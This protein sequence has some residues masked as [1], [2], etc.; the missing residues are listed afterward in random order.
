MARFE[1]AIRIPLLEANHELPARD[2]VLDRFKDLF[3]ARMTAVA[4]P[5]APEEEPVAEAAPE[6]APP[7]RRALRPVPAPRPEP[8]ARVVPPVA[9]PVADEPVA[10]PEA[11]AP[12]LEEEPEAL[13]VATPQPVEA[14][15]VRVAPAPADDDDDDEAWLLGE[16]AAVLGDRPARA[17]VPNAPTP[18]PEWM[19]ERPLEP[20]TA[21]S[22]AEDDEAGTF[23]EDVEP[24]PIPVPS[25]SWEDDAAAGTFD[26]EPEAAAT[27]SWDEE[28]DEKTSA[29]AAFDAA[30]FDE[31]EPEPEPEPDAE[32]DGATAMMPAF[33]PAALDG[34][35]SASG[36]GETDGALESDEES[37]EDGE[38]GDKKSPDGAKRRG[39]R[40][41]G[42]KGRR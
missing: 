31:P 14:A 36:E 25:A 10:A 26:P 32:L 6:P 30:D 27:P 29:M 28:P 37:G 39:R 2:A 18:P 3:F 17:P 15:P 34:G 9:E 21:S 24:A 40:R 38:A 16:A 19:E 7:P 35:E 41:R 1:E 22:A 20:I 42:G 33:D 8:V 11:V 4:A 13:E 5:E 23:D 12:A